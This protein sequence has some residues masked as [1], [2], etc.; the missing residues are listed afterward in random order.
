MKE[1]KRP[2]RTLPRSK[3]HHR[4][5]LDACKGGKP[6]SGNFEYAARLTEIVLLG[7]VALRTGMKLYWDG[8]G[9]KASNASEAEPFIKEQYRKGWEIA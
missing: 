1:Y 2:A 7:N 6:A 4:D 9:L 8:P 3:G 5:W